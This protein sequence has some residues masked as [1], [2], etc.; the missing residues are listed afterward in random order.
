MSSQKN[1]IREHNLDLIKKQLFQK[2]KLLASELVKQ[3]GI[4]MVTV[5]SLLK[6]LVQ[7]QLVLEGKQV[8]GESGR[9]AVE[10]HFNYDLSHSLLLSLEEASGKLFI[11]SFLIDLAGIVLKEEQVAFPDVQLDSFIRILQLQLTKHPFEI[12]NISISIPG[13]IY[14][15]VIQSS[16]HDKLDGWNLAQA[17]RE[18]SPLP[19][20]IQNDAH[21]VTI[22]HCLLKG[23]SFEEA[24]VG[25]YF[26]RQSMPGVTIL[27]HGGL[28]EGN[29]GLAG[30]AKYLPNMINEHFP[31]DDEQL[32]KLLSALLPLYNAVIAPKRFVIA[33]NGVSEKLLLQA[34]RVN[35]VLSRQPN[36]AEIEFVR[37][38][39]QSLLLGLH[40]LIYQGTPYDLSC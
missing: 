3:T 35:Q 14:N 28:L 17:I 32:A 1:L 31:C 9:P 27:A 5:N 11:R 26:P 10:Y 36:T 16:W 37:D 15:G 7:E 30:E 23:I 39:Q 33:T 2:G 19:F 38:F 34:I 6:E 4:S 20:F 22:G 24:T 18:V 29:Q 40:W 13:K 25:I 8:Q 21:L 12:R